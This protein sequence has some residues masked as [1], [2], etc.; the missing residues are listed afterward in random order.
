MQARNFEM[1]KLDKYRAMSCPCESPCLTMC[2]TMCRAL[3]LMMYPTPCLPHF[4]LRPRQK[5]FAKKR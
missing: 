3:S 4:L 1:E 2:L 5:C